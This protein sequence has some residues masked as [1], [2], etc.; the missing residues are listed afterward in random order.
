MLIHKVDIIYQVTLPDYENQKNL[1]SRERVGGGLLS[2]A[3]VNKH[4]CFTLESIH[5]YP[6]LCEWSETSWDEDKDG[7]SEYTVMV[8]ECGCKREYRQWT[9]S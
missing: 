8:Q 4:R 1:L 2:R 3:R 6:A 5:D 9:I 7:V